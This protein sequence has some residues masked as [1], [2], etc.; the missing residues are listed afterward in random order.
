VADRIAATVDDLDT[1][2]RDIRTAIF[3][4]RTPAVTTL[5]GELRSSVDDAAELLGFGP[6]LELTGPIDSAVPDE[7]RPDLLAVVQEA[8]SNVVRHA[9]ACQAQVAVAAGNG[10]L[11]VT[12]HDDGVGPAGITERSGLAN[13]RRRAERH[14][15]TF[16]ILAG[17]PGGTL[18]EWTVPL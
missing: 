16:A 13:L 10:R 11:T 9:Q 5:R 15:G 18:L 4:L 1:T 6:V 17:N 7:I 14:G 2:I 12:V 8:L 3:E